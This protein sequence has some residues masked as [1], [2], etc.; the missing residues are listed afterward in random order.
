GDVPRGDKN[1]GSGGG[2]HENPHPATEGPLPQVS[3]NQQ[4]VRP[5]TPSA[6]LPA[7]PISP[8]IVGP[9]SQPPPPGVAVG[10]PTGVMADAPSPGPGKGDGLGGREGSGAG[11]GS[12][13]SS[14]PGNNGTGPGGKN[15]IGLPGG[16]DDFRGPIPYNLIRNFP[17]STGIVWLY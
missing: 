10:V 4:I 12:G 2:G 5:N 16:R 9:D 15:R 13:A 14:G 17:D 6:P 11:P 8:T 7:I 3:P 1:A